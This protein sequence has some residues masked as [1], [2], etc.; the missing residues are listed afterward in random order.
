MPFSSK[1]IVPMKEVRAHFTALAEDVCAGQEKI[2]T[3]N[4]KAYVALIDAERLDYYHQLERQSIHLCLID[5]VEAGLDDV[6][7][8]N[9]LSVA[10]LK[11]AYGL[12]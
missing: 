8:G 9:L 2:I 7:Q 3:R 10:E 5:E 4:G 11:A 1:D 12:D 6:E